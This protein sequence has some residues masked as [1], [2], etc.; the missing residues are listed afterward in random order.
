LSRKKGNKNRKNKKSPVAVLC[1]VLGTVLLIVLILACLPL[2]VPKVF[3]YHIY[4]VVSGS[5]EPEIPIGSLVYIESIPAAE[6]QKEEVIAFYGVMDTSSII[7]HRV[8]ANST[9]MGQ[10]ITKG[11]AN[12]TNDMNPVPYD[13]YIGKVVLTIPVVGGL[14]QTFTVGPGRIAAVCM[15]GAA[16]LLQIIAAFINSR[17]K[18]AEDDGQA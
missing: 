13:N 18:D 1:S 5:M 7:T 2:T 16:V 4:T 17:K 9:N 8:V 15:I 14:A 3:G 10:F 6:V 11:D 12:D